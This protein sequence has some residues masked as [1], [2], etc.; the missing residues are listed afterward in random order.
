MPRVEVAELV[1]L[2]VLLAF[3]TRLAEQ[4]P[5]REMDGLAGVGQMEPTYRLLDEVVVDFDLVGAAATLSQVISAILPPLISVLRWLAPG[6]LVWWT[7]VSSLGRL[8]V[9]RKLWGRLHTRPATLMRSKISPNGWTRCSQ[10]K[11][12]GGSQNRAERDAPSGS[13]NR[14]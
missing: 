11:F 12:S 4:R 6:L 3:R 5:Q 13:T 10:V 8:L 9:L 7:V 14:R 1:V 2:G